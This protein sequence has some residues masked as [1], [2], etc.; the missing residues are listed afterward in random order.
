MVKHPYSVPHL[1]TKWWSNFVKSALHANHELAHVYE[2]QRIFPGIVA[3]NRKE[4]PRHPPSN[5]GRSCWQRYHMQKVDAKYFT[6]Y[7]IIDN[8]TLQP[9]IFFIRAWALSILFL[10]SN[11]CSDVDQRWAIKTPYIFKKL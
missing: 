2:Y 5:W 7:L 11:R 3:D 4:N 6:G 1:P 9:V 8:N 10:K